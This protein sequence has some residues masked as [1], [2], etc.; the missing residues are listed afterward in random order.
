MQTI[1]TSI[2]WFDKIIPDGLPVK[3]TTIITG[4][5]G[6]GKPLIGECVL[7][8]WLKNGG[9]A[10]IISLQYP[11]PEFVVESVK[12]ITGTDINNYKDNLISI[13][14]NTEIQD[15]E[16][17]NKQLIEANLLKPE[18]WEQTLNFAEK[19]LPESDLGTM[20]FV[21]ALNLL[22]FSPT[23]G[24]VI[25][26]K[27]K[28]TIKRN[29]HLTYVISVS[30]SAKKEKITQLEKMA[31]NLILSHS[32][33]EPFRLFMTIKRLKAGHFEHNEIQIPVSVDT[34]NHIKEMAG[35]SR[36][37]VLPAILKI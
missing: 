20:V 7:S 30:T 27:I 13:R 22:F 37:K 2:D 12:N 23:Y 15:Y 16:Q 8:S 36:E 18:V 31:D 35:H 24:D 33:K 9:S 11:S 32:E 17:T 6:S 29:T 3:S 5:G 19:Q 26:D 14:L 1:K 28:E 34:L 4:P 21:S 10:V 25:F